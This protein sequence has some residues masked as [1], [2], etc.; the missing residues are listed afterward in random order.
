MPV[1]EHKSQH[2]H[3]DSLPLVSK[4]ATVSEVSAMDRRRRDEVRARLLDLGARY[5]FDESVPE[6]GAIDWDTVFERATHSNRKLAPR[7]GALRDRFKRDHPALVRIVLETDEPVGHAAGQYVSIRY[8]SRTRAYSIASS[9]NRDETELCVRRVP[10]GRL[11]RRLCGD[12]SVGDEVTIRGPNGHLL[13]EDVSRRDAVFLATGTGVAPMKSMID[14]TFEE[15][16]DEYRGDDRDVWLFLGAAWED[17]LPYHE[18]FL[19]RA[20]T[21]DNFHYVPC[22]SREPWLSDWDGETE[23]IQDALLKYVDERS[24]EDATFGRHMAELLDDRPETDIGARLDPHAMEVYACGINAMVY[25]LETA[26][27]RL[28]VPPRHVHCEGYG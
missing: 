14:Y 2:D 1:R 25:S 27:R 13:L 10:D 12:L 20:Q 6:R 24:L 18:A 16:R 23:Y 9:P 3:V 7:I 19:D 4:S 28:G 8:G 5:G 22:L 26:V 11:S 21:H 15:E 17:D